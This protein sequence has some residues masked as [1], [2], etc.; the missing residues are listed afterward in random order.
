MAATGDNTIDSLL[1]R[2]LALLDEYTQ[3]RTSLNAL[4]SG[5]YQNLA[6]ANFS[7]ERDIR[8]GQDYYDERMQATRRVEAT[9]TKGTFP[10]FAVIRPEEERSSSTPPPSKPPASD[11]GDDD[12]EKTDSAAE[13]PTSEKD[14]KDEGGK[15]EEPRQQ[16]HKTKNPPSDPLRWFGLLT[17]MTLRLAQGQAIQAAEEL[18]PRLVSVSAEMADVEVEVRRAR[19]KRA[20][21]DA[22][23]EK[24]RRQQV[25]EQEQGQEK[26]Q[27]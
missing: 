14:G 22:A 13:P 12:G 16:Q 9:I 24:R 3:L 27:E 21:A 23:E 1:Q 25:Q 19:K 4:Q 17:P 15:N 2:Y 5:L 18:I 8:Y 10:T 11:A 20:K 7:A 6:R 26:G